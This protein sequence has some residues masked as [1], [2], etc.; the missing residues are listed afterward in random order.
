[1]DSI[2]IFKKLT[3]NLVFDKN[4]ETLKRKIDQVEEEEQPASKVA[5][6]DSKKSA[7]KSK[8]LKKDKKEKVNFIL[9]RKDLFFF[10]GYK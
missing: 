9:I 4:K 7:K 6:L 5:V 2:D 10:F 3:A 8:K 1:M